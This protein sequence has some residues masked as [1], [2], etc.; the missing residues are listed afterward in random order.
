MVTTSQKHMKL[1]QNPPRQKPNRTF[2]VDFSSINKLTNFYWIF[3][4][5]WKVESRLHN[6]IFICFFHGFFPPSMMM[7]VTG[8]L[9]VVNRW[10]FRLPTNC[11][12]IQLS[13]I[14][15]RFPVLKFDPVVNFLTWFCDIEELIECRRMGKEK[16]KEKGRKYSSLCWISFV[17]LILLLL[18]HSSE[19]CKRQIKMNIR[20]VQ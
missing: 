13:L 19:N 7:I 18:F 11:V 12:R 2:H 16:M 3:N 9:T 15:I 1:S 10:N 17:C 6:S 4:N 14:C 5:D 20:G 8:A